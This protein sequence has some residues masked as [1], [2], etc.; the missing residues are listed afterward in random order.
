M[1]CVDSNGWIERFA[2]GPKSI[3]YNKVIDRVESGDIV[4]PVVILNEVCRKI[5][6][7]RGG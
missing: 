3:R 1:I 5:K 6:K 4:T 2:D 7:I